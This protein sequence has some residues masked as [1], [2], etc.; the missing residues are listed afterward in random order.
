MVA[1]IRS[2]P[3]VVPDMLWDN[4]DLEVIATDTDKHGLALVL[5]PYQGLSEQMVEAL[6]MVGLAVEQTHDVA[7]CLTAISRKKPD[8]LIYDGA[9]ASATSGFRDKVEKVRV[10][11]TLPMLELSPKA[12]SCA[13]FQRLTPLVRQTEAFLKIRALLRRERP[14]ALTG[15]RHQGSLVLDEPGFKL[16]AGTACADI[17]KTDLCILGPFF[18]VKASVL[19]RHSLACLAFGAVDWQSDNRTVDAYISRLRRNVRDQ[20][21]LDPLRSVRGLGY[22]LTDE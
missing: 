17:S 8:I 9:V 21:G 2:V 12:E 18:D 13:N 4:T 20:I 22:A 15:Q 14:S 3:F 16:C 19:D 6:A 10:T 11:E 7:T 5:V 1:A